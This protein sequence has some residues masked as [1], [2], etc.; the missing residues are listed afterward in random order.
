MN[1]QLTWASIGPIP[2]TIFVWLTRRLLAIK[3]SVPLPTDGAVIN[4]SVLLVKA[5]A[6]QMKSTLQAIKDFD[7]EINKLCAAHPDFPLFQSL[8]GAG[9]VYA[10]RLL[11]VIGS[12]R[13]RWSTAA[14][15]ACLSGIAPV[16]AA[17][18]QPGFA[19]ATSAPSSCANHFMSSP[20]S[21]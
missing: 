18:N 4:S 15:L 13:Q 9:E 12:D 17:A 14:E 10:S 21:R 5:L 8:P 11:A 1:S 19:G 7:R 6:A 3:Q 16:I 20:P 2:N